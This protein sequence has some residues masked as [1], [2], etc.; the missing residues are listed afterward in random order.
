LEIEVQFYLAL[1]LLAYVYK[2][3]ATWL[4]RAIIVA[5]GVV[6]L[7][8]NDALQQ[9]WTAWH[10]TFAAYLPMFCGGLLLADVYLVDWKRRPVRGHAW[11]A[12]AL[13]AVAALLAGVW[14]GSAVV[15]VALPVSCYVLAAAV[16]RG[17]V[18]GALL[19]NR[20]LAVIGGMCYSIYLCHTQVITATGSWLLPQFASRGFFAVFAAIA[21]FCV[22][23]VLLVSAAFY[24]LVERPC[25]RRDWAQRLWARVARQKA[26]APSS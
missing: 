10:Y 19:T 11:D 22:P 4:R 16:F 14:W 2:L 8:G 9:V 17:S 24:K 23:A 26:V 25:M 21:L 12:A 13:V 15:M 6:T 20:W 18:T 5:A 1:P 3:R 7:F